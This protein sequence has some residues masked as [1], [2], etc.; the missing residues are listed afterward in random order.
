MPSGLLEP[1]A[2]P[3]PVGPVF[4]AEGAFEVALFAPDH[5]APD[6]EHHQGQQEHR[7]QG[8]AKD[9]DPGV[10]RRQ[11]ELARVAAVAERAPG[12]E[13][14]HGPVGPYRHPLPPHRPPEPSGA[15]R[16]EGAVPPPPPPIAPSRAKR[17]APPRS[18]AAATPE[19]SPPWI[20][21]RARASCYPGPP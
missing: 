19:P 3:R 8:V 15:R 6:D 14:R 11:C 2:H 1:A 12:R 13:P 5:L 18:R 4:L 21:G 7:P 16:P 20:A 17:C 10:H 9:G